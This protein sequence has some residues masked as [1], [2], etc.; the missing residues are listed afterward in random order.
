M[1]GSCNACPSTCNNC[2]D[3]VGCTSCPTG[4]YVLQGQCTACPAGF[5]NNGVS[6]VQCQTGCTACT[7]AS[8]CTSPASGFYL[9]NGQAAACSSNCAQCNSSACQTCNS[10]SALVN[11]NCVLNCQLGQYFDNTTNTCLGCPSN[12]N[13]C[14]ESLNRFN[15]TTQVVCTQCAVGYFN[16]GSACNVPSEPSAVSAPT[17]PATSYAGVSPFFSPQTFTAND[18]VIYVQYD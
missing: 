4:T 6:C 12:C 8:Q 10:G 7:G 15:Q 18:A 9:S 17:I 3:N 11:G 13:S 16:N 5:F 14:Y 2:S 1:F